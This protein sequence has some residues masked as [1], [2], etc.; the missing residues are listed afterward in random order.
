MWEIASQVSS[1]PSMVVLRSA[2]LPPGEPKPVKA[3]SP[4]LLG[5]PAHHDGWVGWGGG[6][7]ADSS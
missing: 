1:E 2:T 3:G 5:P 7:D 6:G 4:P